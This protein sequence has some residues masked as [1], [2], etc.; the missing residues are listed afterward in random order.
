ML[1]NESPLKQ[2][3]D[4]FDISHIDWFE[5]EYKKNALKENVREMGKLV[6]SD[7]VW[8][9]EHFQN[10]VA[11]WNGLPGKGKSMPALYSACR[12]GQIF[13][14][15]F[16]SKNIFWDLYDLQ[17]AISILPKRATVFKDE[18]RNESTGYMAKQEQ[19]LM[20]DLVEQLREPKQIN[21]FFASVFN[22]IHADFFRFEAMNIDW[23][24]DMT[25]PPK[26][27]F[28]M[29][30][31]PRYTACE[32]FVWRGM[33]YFPFPP[34]QIDNEYKEKKA[35]AQKELISPTGKRLNKID[36]LA[37]RIFL[38]KQNELT[39]ATK[40]GVIIPLQSDLMIQVIQSEPGIGHF[41]IPVLK[42]LISTL[43]DMVESFYAEQNSKT[44][45]SS[46]VEKEEKAKLAAEL[47]AKIEAEK[48]EQRERRFELMRQKIEEMRLTR[49]LKE[50]LFALKLQEATEKITETDKNR[51]KLVENQAKAMQE[52][53]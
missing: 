9:S 31:T 39:R 37:K 14:V 20:H 38:K 10:I 11:S 6:N 7:W 36:I 49:Q 32:D 33:V 43:R 52:V 1:A 28:S 8:R 35:L 3:F 34:A 45:I 46:S 4:K 17:N 18:H 23:N 44:E 22:E 12:S 41:T 13:N 5:D 25:K 2:Y 24:D 48:K 27:F 30:S 51:V 19:A 29:L 50:K 40:T 53:V 16:S 42:M 47:N 15:P 26:G 21:F